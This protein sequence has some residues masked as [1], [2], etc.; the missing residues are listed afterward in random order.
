MDSIYIQFFGSGILLGLMA[1]ISPGP[2]LALTISETYRY[3]FRNGALV[4]VAPILTDVP[5]VVV[6]LWF[7]VFLQ[8]GLEAL[9]WIQIGGAIY[10]VWL[11]YECWQSRPEQALSMPSGTLAP[12]LGRGLLTNFLSPHPYL[13]W[14]SIGAPQLRQAAQSGV[15]APGLFLLGF[16]ATLVG[17]KVAIA[18]AASRSRRFIGGRGYLF[19]LRFLAFLLWMF[20]L[21]LLYQ[22]IL[23]LR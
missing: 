23:E 4:A 5:I 12:S 13:F 17:G 15:V 16:Y 10:L 7:V 1:G 22:G 18:L 2:L 14:L 19:V 20:A 11:G 21:A 3:G 6:S 8:S 9:L